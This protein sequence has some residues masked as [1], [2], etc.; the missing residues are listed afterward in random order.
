MQRIDGMENGQ[1]YIGKCK[2]N[3]NEKKLSYNNPHCTEYFCNPT[4][5]E[6]KVNAMIFVLLSSEKVMFF[7]CT[8]V[9]PL[10]ISKFVFTGK[11]PS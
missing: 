3:N 8:T 10:V 1:Y 4:S 9:R 6:G 5:S 2:L 7:R 11:S